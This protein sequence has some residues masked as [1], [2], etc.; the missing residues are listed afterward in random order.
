MSAQYA[1]TGT[2]TLSSFF[3]SSVDNVLLQT[4]PDFEGHFLNSAT[5]LNVIWWTHCCMTVKPCKVV[6]DRLLGATDPER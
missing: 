3:D 4:N 5:F 6:I 2:Q 1:D